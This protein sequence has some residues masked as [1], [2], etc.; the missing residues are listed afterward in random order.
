M[1]FPFHHH[2]TYEHIPGFE[3][4]ADLFCIS[5]SDVLQVTNPPN[6][7]IISLYVKGGQR[8]M[9]NDKLQIEVS[10]EWLLKTLHGP[11]GSSDDE[12]FN[13]F[14]T[15]NDSEVPQFSSQLSDTWINCYPSGSSDIW[16]L[17]QTR[18]R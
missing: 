14:V 7:G 17:F 3:S 1:E 10:F 18:L 9:L 16:S 8:T 11:G 2:H 12:Q 15:H 4:P 13:G 5:G 6:V